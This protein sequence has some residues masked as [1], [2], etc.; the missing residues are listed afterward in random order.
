M[1]IHYQFTNKQG[2]EGDE[3][4]IMN[5]HKTQERCLETEH[6]PQVYTF[7]S[8]TGLYCV[9]VSVTTLLKR[10]FLEN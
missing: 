3:C 5:I 9:N 8:Y 10:H 4:S 2:V 1:F 6:V 7:S